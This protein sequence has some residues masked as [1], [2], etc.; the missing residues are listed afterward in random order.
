MAPSITSALT[1]SGTACSAFSYTV[2]ATGTTPM[3]FGATGLPAGLS[4]N[5]STGLISGTPTS[6]GTTNVG[7]SAT[8]ACGTDNKTLVI[9]IG[10]YHCGVS[11]AWSGSYS[12]SPGDPDSSTC[13]NQN[14]V[15]FSPCTSANIRVQFTVSNGGAAQIQIYS[16]PGSTLLYD[17]GCIVADGGDVNVDQTFGS[18]S[19]YS[20]LTTVG[21]CG[22]SGNTGGSVAGGW[23]C[24]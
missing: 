5:S 7:I 18:G 15:T 22:C 14:S 4:I 8:N 17:S 16:N 21:T 10:A 3:T 11:D 20:S 2:V 19:G 23:A 1:A 6:A 13:I 12:P 9:T 24:T